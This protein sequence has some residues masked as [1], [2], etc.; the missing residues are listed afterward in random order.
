MQSVTICSSISLD[1]ATCTPAEKSV[2][3][4]SRRKRKIERIWYEVKEFINKVL[5]V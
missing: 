2:T 4:M 1:S 3:R 5:D